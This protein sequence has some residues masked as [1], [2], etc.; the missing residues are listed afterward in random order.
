MLFIFNLESGYVGFPTGK[1]TCD[2]SY[3]V[4]V[5]PKVVVTFEF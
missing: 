1:D 4:Q 3:V 2:L 5:D